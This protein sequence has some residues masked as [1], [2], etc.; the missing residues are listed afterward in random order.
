MSATVSITDQDVFRAM[1][2][3]LLEVLPDGTEIV[4]LQGN[5]VSMPEGAFVGMNNGS[6]RRL[7]TNRRTYTAG[8]SNP[9]EKAVTT[10][11]AYAMPLD[12]YGPDS[13]AWAAMVQSLF[14]DEFATSRFPADI[15]PLYADDPIQIPLITGE[16]TYE[17]RWR[18]E[19]V[20]QTNTVVTVDQD[21][22]TS[23]Q[24]GLIEVDST[25]P[26]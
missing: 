15:Q 9:G 1:R 19:A 18:L 23:L 7:S 6:N 21:C 10:P 24:V 22:A 4:Q 11:S 25:Y 5:G 2:A 14:R 20:L 8:S 12:F 3:F 26:A 17:Q 13:G 16:Q